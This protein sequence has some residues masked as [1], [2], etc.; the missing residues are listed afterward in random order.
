MVFSFFMWYNK[1]SKSKRRNKTMREKTFRDLGLE[2]NRI[3]ELNAMFDLESLLGGEVPQPKK[4]I[5][6]LYATGNASKVKQVEEYLRAMD[7]EPYIQSLKD[8]GFHEEIQE[9]GQTFEANSYIKAEAVKNYCDKKG[10]HTIVIADDAGLC[11]DALKGA[12]GVLSARYAGDHAPQNVVLD[13]LLAE[14][15]EVPEEKRTAQFVCVLTA[16][17]P[18]GNI[19][20]AKGMVKG[21][22]GTAYEVDNKLTYGPV[23]IPEGSDKP[24][25]KMTGKELGKLH[26]EIALEKL[27]EQLDLQ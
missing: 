13:K 27:M 19:V 6:F 5:H 18:N 25:A 1:P 11:V 16:I 23:F 15:K 3:K 2:D 9:D 10:I 22:I 7:I 21:K 24:M 17:L 8:I 14:L 4:E 12:P 20:T 26:R